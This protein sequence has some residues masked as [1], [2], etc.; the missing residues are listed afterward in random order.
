MAFNINDDVFLFPKLK[1]EPDCFSAVSISNSIDLHAIDPD[2][3]F[4]YPNLYAIF[5]WDKANLY[6]EFPTYCA[7]IVEFAWDPTQFANYRYSPAEKTAA[8][9]DP[10]YID[11]L[12]HRVGNVD[13]DELHY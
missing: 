5:D 11:Y 9:N 2:T 6:L 1:S 10:A 13:V 3:D 4:V 7:S 8:F 12:M